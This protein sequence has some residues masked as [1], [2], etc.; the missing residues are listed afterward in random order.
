MIKSLLKRIVHLE[1]VQVDKENITQMILLVTR[2]AN[3]T[4]FVEDYGIAEYIFESEKEYEIQ[5]QKWRKV[6]DVL[7]HDITNLWE[8]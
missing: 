8:E 4:I 5:L 2:K 6:K 1:K 3:G 7:E